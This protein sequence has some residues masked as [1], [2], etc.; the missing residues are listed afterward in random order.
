MAFYT[1]LSCTSDTHHHS[2]ALLSAAC[3][4]EAKRALTV[5][6]E[7]AVSAALDF[8]PRQGC[9]AAATNAVVY[10]VCTGREG[11]Q[12]PICTSLNHC[13]CLYTAPLASNLQH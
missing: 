5:V 4:A 11:G 2:T 8:Q 13:A 3:Y 1:C 9:L 10:K 12:I 7:P 6:H